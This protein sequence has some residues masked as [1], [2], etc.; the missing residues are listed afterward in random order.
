MTRMLIRRKKRI[1]TRVDLIS[2]DRSGSCA[3]TPNSDASRFRGLVE[4]IAAYCLV[5][6]AYAPRHGGDAGA[7]RR[8]AD[9]LGLD[10]RA[11]D[12]QRQIRVMGFDRL[13]EPFG[14]LALARQRA[15]PFAFVIGDAANLPLRQFEVDQRQRGIGPGTGARSGARSV[16]SFRAVP[17]DG[18]RRQTS[19]DDVRQQLCRHRVRVAKPVGE[20][21]R[22]VRMFC[23]KRHG[24]I[25]HLARPQLA[26][27]ALQ[28]GSKRHLKTRWGGRPRY[29]DFIRLSS[30]A[31]GRTCRS[32]RSGPRR[33]ASR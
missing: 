28:D 6:R 12:R 2:R 10:E 30:G 26:S 16:R 8:R 7:A 1:S 14:K 24:V 19:V 15:M 4:I 9:A 5:R 33:G 13:I 29:R 21:S 31:K 20:P 11:Q 27:R 3:K 23:S 17:V 22:I 18:K 32:G 25:S